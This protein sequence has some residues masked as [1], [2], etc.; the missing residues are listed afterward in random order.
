MGSDVVTYW[1]D[2]AARQPL[3]S[4]GEELH[5][6]AMVRRWQDHPGGPDK[7]PAAVQ[8]RGRRAR[9]RIVT[10]NLRLV[11]HIAARLRRN[12]CGA[13][14]SME[15]VLQAG[16]IGLQRAAER[17]DPARG[18][19]FSTFAYWW[20]R[21]TVSREAEASSL[22]IRLPARLAGDVMRLE[23]TRY[24]LAQELGRMPG[25]NELA[26]AVGMDPQELLTYEKRGRG[27]KSLDSTLIDSNNADCLGD[28]LSAP[29]EEP[30]P[31]LEELRE[32]LAQLDPQ[33]YRIIARRWFT[34]SRFAIRDIAAQEGIE[35]RQVLRIL[36]DSLAALCR[37]V[38][39]SLPLADDATMGAVPTIP[40][41]ARAA[42]PVSR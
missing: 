17:F 41:D 32:R 11:S 29:V 22:T 12:G 19:K 8:R 37:E 27:C 33:S 3:L 24:Q 35:S 38:Q 20:I 16:A 5:L 2:N 30:D 21:Q 34:H 7:A 40:A 39:G 6:G 9:D 23:R 26:A 10:A 28:L 18:Y 13:M 14:L 31:L 25:V 1:L 42:E 15:D 36:S 4:H